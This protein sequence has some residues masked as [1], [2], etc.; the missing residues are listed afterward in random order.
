VRAVALQVALLCLVKVAVHRGGL[1]SLSVSP[2]FSAMVASTVFLLG[3][4]LSGVLTDYKESE[5]IP[6]ELA[7][8]LETLSL[9]LRAIPMYC[10]EAR[11]QA[12]L[13]GV[14]ELGQQ[15]HL[16]LLERIPVDL[17]LQRYWQVHAEVVAASAQF[18]GEASTLR[19][20]LMQCLETVLQRVN[21]VQTIRDTTFVPLVYWMARSAALLLIAGLVLASTQHLLESVFFLAVIAFLVILLLRLIDDIDN[22]FGSASATSAE[23]VSLEILQRTVERLQA[24]LTSL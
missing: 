23:D 4:L 21:R 20:R 14:A 2:L 6:A 3:F 15:V 17:L 12:A 5:K 10:P 11:V 16:W 22:P 9:E 7:T 19:G 1:E 13:Q 24:A 18:S 8:A